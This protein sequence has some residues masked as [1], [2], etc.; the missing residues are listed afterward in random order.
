MSVK[1]K[2][3]N[4]IKSVGAAPSHE[5]IEAI[6]QVVA[7]AQPQRSVVH[8]NTSGFTLPRDHNDSQR[9][10]T[11]YQH[12]YAIILRECHANAKTYGATKAYTTRVKIDGK[13]YLLYASDARPFEDENAI[14]T[15]GLTPNRTGG[16]GHS[17]QGNGLTYT[18]CYMQGRSREL[19]IGSFTT[20]DGF[21]AVSVM[22][23]NNLIVHTRKPELHTKLKRCFGEDKLAE[24]KVFY[25]I[26]IP[27]SEIACMAAVSVSSLPFLCPDLLDPNSDGS[28]S[29]SLRWSQY[30]WCDEMTSTIDWTNNT[31][32]W[33]VIGRREY[34]ARFREDLRAEMPATILLAC[35]DYDIK[36]RLKVVV[37]C[38]SGI[39]VGGH[40]WFGH[41]R[42]NP[43]GWVKIGAGQE[44]WS[45][46]S[47]ST[48]VGRTLFTAFLVASA[49]A[50]GE[51]NRMRFAME[52]VFAAYHCKSFFDSMN[53]YYKDYGSNSVH[54]YAT[55]EVFIEQIEGIR[56]HE[57]EDQ[58]FEPLPPMEFGEKM[59]RR[60]DF[61]FEEE[62]LC[63]KL[64]HEAAAAC[65][66][67]VP[68]PIRNW[69]DGNFPRE[70]ADFC[71]IVLSNT[72]KTRRSCKIYDLEQNGAEVRGTLQL[73][74]SQT[75]YFIVEE[76]DRILNALT[77]LPHLKGVTFNVCQATGQSLAVLP[78]SVKQGLQ[79]FCAR[80]LIPPASISI[81][82]VTV[83]ALSRTDPSTGVNTAIDDAQYKAYRDSEGLANLLPNSRRVY[84][85]TNGKSWLFG[86]IDD[87]PERSGGHGGGGGGGGNTGGG[88]GSDEQG[89]GHRPDYFD[90]GHPHRAMWFKS[91]K[92]GSLVLNRLY[93][94]SSG[95]MPWAPFFH[96]D[97]VGSATQKILQ[98][99]YESLLI[100]C[101]SIFANGKVVEK[102]GDLPIVDENNLPIYE[103]ALDRLLNEST[104]KWLE[105]DPFIKKGLAKVVEIRSR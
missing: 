7:A 61:L 93:E 105:Q 22:A 54:P 67:D 71:P 65:R 36:L 21:R 81:H 100:R 30:E 83:D 3:A 46:G 2:S 12:N 80:K 47:Q 35:R 37:S 103:D 78:Q 10:Y 56:F 27:A 72:G 55:L 90:D 8:V 15:L 62:D 23:Q 14:I 84:T 6:E 82:V 58:D 19:I 34:D 94:T 16:E 95:V 88:G 68:E 97:A 57:D 66:D 86:I 48:G 31:W 11:T 75:R 74:T 99:V 5:V 102:E 92:D 87:V 20:T 104:K 43:E 59:G 42:D 91:D 79:S 64:M 41:V 69:F 96:P 17:L 101:K 70:A 29:P 76:N 50:T 85:T 44:S 9:P 24:Y 18:A 33:P 38:Y 40:Q 63:R 51:P 32:K 98:D 25:L 77:P 49:M 45:Q 53:L 39:D 52:P 28:Q 73:S 89:E 4:S 1:S 13:S 60:A 26:G